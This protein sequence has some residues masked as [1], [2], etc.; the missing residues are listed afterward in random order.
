MRVTVH[1]GRLQGDVKAV[2]SKSYAHRMLIAAAQADR[3]TDIAFD[4]CG[5]DVETTLDCLTALG[6]R[7]ERREGGVRIAPI[8]PG[9]MP[10]EPVLDC[11]ESGSTLRFLLPLACCVEKP[12]RLT[13][14]GRLPARP[15]SD[16]VEQL[17]AHG[18]H[19][20]GD[21]LP[22]RVSGPLQGGVYALPGDVS[23][24]YLTGLLLALP[25]L[26][27]DSRLIL[28][29]PLQSKG[30]VDMTL[31]VLAQ[32]GIRVEQRPDGYLIPGGQ[33]WT[34]PGRMQVEGDWSGAAFWVVANVLGSRVNVQ[35]LNASSLQGDARVVSA[36]RHLS[37]GGTC[38]LDL[39]DIPDLMPALA[40][41][42]TQTPGT[43]HLTR[44]ARLRLKES[45]RLA[46]MA[47]GLTRLGGRIVQEEDA[48]T[49]EGNQRLTGG[50]VDA[51]GDHRIAMAA[52]VAALAA[53]S[54]VVIEGAECV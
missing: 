41:A 22:L 35:G 36:A 20:E 6:A 27:Q 26:P 28:T 32:F 44:L 5:A 34:G 30:Y 7:V 4:P 23:S 15:L 51:Y 19:V 48:W 24:Q 40:V 52:A 11:G 17:R 54:P 31:E 49:I 25:R 10:D 3:V 14:R 38:T 12:V 37:Q 42:A 16:L 50:E 9:S 2:P 29:S 53:E 43:T 8:Q 33:R 21:F 45:D 13:G 18:T 39:S 46:A 1:P 47:E